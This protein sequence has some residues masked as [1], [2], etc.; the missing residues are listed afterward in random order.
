MSDDLNEQ[1]IGPIGRLTISILPQPVEQ[2]I[3]LRGGGEALARTLHLLGFSVLQENNSGD[4]RIRHDAAADQVL[5]NL[6]ELIC[7]V[8]YLRPGFNQLTLPEAP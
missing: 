3:I 1:T 7:A 6:F 4:C 8:R 5:V 2:I